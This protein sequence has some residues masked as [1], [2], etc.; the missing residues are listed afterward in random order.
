[1]GKEVVKLASS[2]TSNDS[3]YQYNI[4]KAMWDSIIRQGSNYNKSF[5]SKKN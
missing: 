2:Y 3:P 4:H 5:E 1:M